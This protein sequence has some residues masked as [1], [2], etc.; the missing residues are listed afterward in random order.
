VAGRVAGV[1][2]KQRQQRRGGKD[3]GLIGSSLDSPLGSSLDDQLDRVEDR[4]DTFAT[5]DSDAFSR[6]VISPDLGFTV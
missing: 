5:K 3:A 2:G 4:F 6:W 1:T